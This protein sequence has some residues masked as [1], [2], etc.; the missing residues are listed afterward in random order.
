MKKETKEVGSG[1]RPKGGVRPGKGILE[2]RFP[3]TLRKTLS[4]FQSVASLGNIEKITG[5][6]KITNTKTKR[7]QAQ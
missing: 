7:L 6:G 3:Q 5:S 1:V 2:E 4:C